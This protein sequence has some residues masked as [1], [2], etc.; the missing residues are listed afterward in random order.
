MAQRKQNCHPRRRHVK[1]QG[2]Q[3]HLGH[4]PSPVVDQPHTTKDI[5]SSPQ[6]AAANVQPPPQYEDQTLQMLAGMNEQTKEQQAQS[7][8]D[9]EQ[10]A[11]DRENVIR[12]QEALRQLNEQLQAQ[13]VASRTPRH[14]HSTKASIESK[15]LPTYESSTS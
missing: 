11:L 7:N 13:I 5:G 3:H 10:A 14:R 8:H 4:G 1:G 9:R 6:K 2:H 12:E 15:N